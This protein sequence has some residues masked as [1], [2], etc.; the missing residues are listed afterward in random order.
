MAL[1]KTYPIFDRWDI[2]WLAERLAVGEAYLA[3][4]KNGH[5]PM[6]PGF[7]LRAS[8]ILRKS[9]AELFGDNEQE[10]R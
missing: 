7:R 1:T 3:A 9:E 2:S 10:E 5:K 8:R 6:R 4:L